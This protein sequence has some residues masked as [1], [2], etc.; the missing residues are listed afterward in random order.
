MTSTMPIINETDQFSVTQAAH[1]LGI[2]RSTLHRHTEE[3]LIKCGFRR[4]T[5]RRFYT[6]KELLKYWKTV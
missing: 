1:I 6:G 3:G 2:H 5:G 4:N